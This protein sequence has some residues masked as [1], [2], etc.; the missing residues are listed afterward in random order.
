MG[1]SSIPRFHKGF[2]YWQ[3]NTTYGWICVTGMASWL[4]DLLPHYDCETMYL[5][6]SHNMPDKHGAVALPPPPPP[7]K[8]VIYD[9]RKPE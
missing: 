4:R 5:S 9:N 3:C 6:K 1:D 7:P 2:L 8:K